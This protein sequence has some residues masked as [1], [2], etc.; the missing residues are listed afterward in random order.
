MNIIVVCLL[1]LYQLYTFFAFGSLIVKISKQEIPSISMTF[2]Y[3]FLYYFIIFAL[4]ALPCIF[5]HQKLSTLTSIWIIVSTIIT[6]SSTTLSFKAWMTLLKAIPEKLK[7]HRWMILLLIFALLM[8]MLF[9]FTHMDNTADASYYIG[10]VTTDVYTDTLGHYDPYT[11][12]QLYSLDTRRVI[13]CFPE[14]NAVISQFFH[15]HPLKQAKLIMPEL[16]ILMINIIYYQIGLLLFNNNRKKTCGMV[17]FIFILN[18]YS[19]TIYTSSTFLLTRTYEGKSIL[20]NL[21]IPGMI[22]CFLSFWKENNISFAKLLLLG[23][24]F[25]SCVFS[26]S[27]MLIVPVGLTAGLWPWIVKEKKYSQLLWYVLCVFPNLLVCVLYLLTSHGY[28]NYTI[29]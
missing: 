25:S 1:A 28:L 20:A 16:I 10:K 18:L 24:S 8:Q 14:Y 29:M 11:G 23:I 3:G 17:F 7:L 13:A 27:S 22:Y 6:L 2:F 5:T 12:K 9:V 26:S 15:I 4:F 21:I 19:Y